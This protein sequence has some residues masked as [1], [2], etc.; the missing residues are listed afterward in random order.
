MKTV[1]KF[2]SSLILAHVALVNVYHLSLR[3][4][5]IVPRI[6]QFRLELAFS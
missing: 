4:S 5:Q 1:F 2:F 3:V 6:E